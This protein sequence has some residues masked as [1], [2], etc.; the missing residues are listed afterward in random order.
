MSIRR[1][2]LC[3]LLAIGA[4]VI[5]AG[6]AMAQTFPAK[7][8]R[9]VVPF[10]P[11]GPIDVIGR[12]IAQHLGNSLGQN[13]IVENRPGAGG[14]LGA[15][16]VANAEPD[17]HT[18]LMGS[19]TTLSIS[20]YLYKDVGYDP[21]KGLVPVATVSTGAMALVVNPNVP[22]KSVKELIDHAKANPGKLNFG[23]GLAS[24]PHL[25]GE[26][27]KVS[28]K[29]DAQFVPY[30][31][32]APAITDLLTGQ[33]QFMIDATGVLLPHIRAG[34]LRVLAVTSGTRSRVLP[35]V[36]TMT[37]SGVPEYIL[38]FWT[39]IVAPTGT[40]AAVI[41]RLNSA[42][43]DSLK[44]P[45]LQASLAKFNIEANIRSPKEAAAFMAGESKK[46]GEIVKATGVKVN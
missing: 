16:A 33:I 45:E 5:A 13:V 23:A 35:E 1:M 28:A 42:I 43:N 32:A 8:L 11:G 29:I 7:P 21:H 3:A 19:T 24:P 26:L 12:L 38:D 44:S 18:L 36:P 4:G 25:A 17:G 10:P 30:K 20:P 22:A 2:I 41:D 46:W 27:F 6:A 40:P 31:G 9:M 15:R 34:K 37:E 14:T 39:G